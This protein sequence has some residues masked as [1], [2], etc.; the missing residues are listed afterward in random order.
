MLAISTWHPSSTV[1]HSVKCKLAGNKESLVIAKAN[2]LEVY[3]LSATGLVLKCTFDIWGIVTSLLAAQR[4][5][6]TYQS[7]L[8]TTDHLNPQFYI[9]DYDV[10]GS[11][12]H[13]LVSYSLPLSV[14]AGREAEFF[15]GAV[16]HPNGKVVVCCAY[17]GTL[18]VIVL[19]GNDGEV[20]T[21]FDCRVP[22]LNIHSMCFVPSTSKMILAILFEDYNARKHVI[23]R[24]LKLDEQELLYEHSPVIA[25]GFVHDLAKSLIPVPGQRKSPGV[26][27][28]G[29]A[30]AHFIGSERVTAKRASR[31]PEV[32]T[33]L[34]A[35]HSLAKSDLPLDQTGEIRFAAIDD[36]RFLISDSNGHLCLLNVT[37][38]G[39]SNT[40]SAIN[41]LDLG[42]VS[43]P[44]TITHISGPFVYIGSQSGDSQTICILPEAGSDGSH[45]KILENYTSIGPIV[46][47]ILVDP[48]NSGQ[49]E[50]VMCSGYASSSS[51]RVIRS[52]AEL[53]KS[54]AL[55][56]FPD[57]EDMF[58]LR[59]QLPA[60]HHSIALFTT[61]SHTTVLE[62]NRSSF[63][64]Q[65]SKTFPGFIRTSRTLAA[66]NIESH[67]RAVQVTTSSIVIV[68]MA[69]S[70]EVD[71]WPPRGSP[72][73][74]IA[75]AAVNPSQILIALKDGKLILFS[76]KLGALRIVSEKT[77]SHVEGLANEISAVSIEPT[78]IGNQLSSNIAAVGC[79]AK[80]TVTIYQ[81][82]ALELPQKLANSFTVREEHVPLS[83][84]LHTFGGSSIYLMIGLGN[85]SLVTYS[86]DP[87]LGLTNRRTM[88]LGVDRPVKLAACQYAAS[89]NNPNPAGRGGPKEKVVLAAG[90]RASILWL[91]QRGKRLR[92]S[93]IAVRHSTALCSIDLSTSSGLGSMLVASKDG[94]M[95]IGRIGELNKLNYRTIP[96]G[97]D[98]PRQIAYHQ[99]YDAFAVGCVRTEAGSITSFVKILDGKTFERTTSEPAVGNLES[100]S[101]RVLVLNGADAKTLNTVASIEVPGCVYALAGIHPGYLTAAV[102][103]SVYVYKLHT[104]EGKEGFRLTKH[105]KWDRGYVMTSIASKGD[106]IAVGDALRS[107]DLLKLERDKLVSV[108]KNCNPLWPLGVE[109]TGK[110]Y[111]IT[112]E[113]D[114]NLSLFKRE[115]SN[116]ERA[117]GFHYGELVNKFIPG[118][119]QSISNEYALIQPELL[120]VTSTGRISVISHIDE[121][122]SL[123][124]TGL[125]R[126]LGYILKGP[127]DLEHS[128]YRT[129]I[130]ARG[131]GEF[132]GFIDGDFVER[133][134][135]LS[136]NQIE[137]AMNGRNEAER[138]TAD[139][140]LIRQI[141]EQ[142]GA[143]HQ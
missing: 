137:K 120:A 128:T 107:V 95:I 72:S 4:K 106:M 13:L 9:L 27:V 80:N 61:S 17:S 40:V 138:L 60:M 109:W 101:G 76:T 15:N 50:M 31:G 56:G 44:S 52:G 25:G 125:Q 97:L 121:A 124:L 81:L 78:T 51:I 73:Q 19:G 39:P 118:K 57:V 134:L 69:S 130:T 77:V 2:T 115:L 55:H 5:G 8:L 142:I 6:R 104:P 64:E 135:D 132:A 20:Q 10:T 7:L 116:L 26:L 117:G 139:V 46:D 21:E 89:P 62:I 136:G 96:L 119:L 24:E 11:Q 14:R 33:A 48:D 22:E 143:L 35:D 66:C 82:P 102:N 34:S 92:G 18:K 79:W 38:N 126:N 70:V 59:L 68:D 87:D 30:Y 45:I 65:D 114:Q 42:L 47:A 32:A 88:S 43:P 91:D 110:D 71:R 12:P 103:T 129:P 49:N 67:G 108:A 37:R 53:R 122:T 28:V 54:A 113:G 74:Q 141:V 140:T 41:T 84:L 1:T 36:S 99:Q 98:N 23:G 3:D 133:F 94:T 100:T 63:D 90:T 127:G 93:T 131:R 58:P 123:L 85:G 29:G 83:L 111:V 16:L 112:A 75:C 105:A 86:V